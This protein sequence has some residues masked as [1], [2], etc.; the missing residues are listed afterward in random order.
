MEVGIDKIV[1][2]NFKAFPKEEVIELGG[3]HLLMYGENGSGKSSIYWALYTLL[4]AKDK[5]TAKTEKYFD[6]GNPEHLL[7]IF[8][9]HDD[10]CIKFSLTDESDVF[11]KL[12][13]NGIDIEGTSTKTDDVLDGLKLSSDFI[14]HRLLITFYHFRNSHK[15]NL[16]PIFE[17]DILP[18]I[19]T[20][21]G[22]APGS[23]TMGELYDN[24]VANK[25]FF[26]NP[27]NGTIEASRRIKRTYLDQIDN[28]NTN[29]TRW[30]T[31]INL[32]VNTFYETH[33][34]V[35]EE[36]KLIINLSFNHANH[37]MYGPLTQER[38]A[39]GHP[40]QQFSSRDIKEL[41]APFIGLSIKVKKQDGS[42]EE[43]HRPQ[44]YLNEAKLT[45]I[46]LS[47]R[48]SLLSPIIRVPYDAKMLVLDDLLI[49]LDMSNR[50]K[51]LDIILN[52]YAHPTDP[53][54]EFKV[55]MFTHDK[56]FFEMAK[57][58]IYHTQ[59]KNDWIFN[60]LYGTINESDIRQPK[61]YKSETHLSRAKQHLRI[62]HDY[63][64]AANYLRKATEELLSKKLPTKALKNE[65]GTNKPRLDSK[66]DVAIRFLNRFSISTTNLIRV[67][68]FVAVLLNPLS[69]RSDIHSKVYRE[70]I[71][72]IQTIIEK[73]E[74]ELEGLVFKE[75]LPRGSVIE[76]KFSKNATT[77]ECYSTSL[78]ADFMI[79]DPGNGAPIVPSICELDRNIS[80]FQTIDGA[81]QDPVPYKVPL[82]SNQC[83]DLRLFYET[84]LNKEGVT[85]TPNH[86][87]NF[88]DQKSGQSVESLIVP[89][90]SPSV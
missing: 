65:D 28:F 44:S 46:A 58:R 8:T 57:N 5:G 90:I 36:E 62:T 55:Y 54:K 12:D 41:R 89:I 70:E 35:P 45:A 24:I 61:N 63:P 77:D 26:F 2:Q 34:Q 64:A 49:S 48:F 38:K 25:P 86:L 56:V 7:N 52:E 72:K 4:Q 32:N 73:L 21:V 88:F 40:P 87:G 59:D 83:D 78:K 67:K 43:V 3:K 68:E 13:L 71:E 11:Y 22:P 80:A 19:K 47:V 27:K 10:S 16:W 53:N 17:R 15:I 23:Q 60:E 42:I 6:R 75:I 9:D 14:S 82:D 79:Y 51:V 85:I 39:P 81:K 76:L 29:L 50:D 31:E 84:I 66:L 1:I 37:L 69:H 20:T 33:F 30:I 18:F 74:V